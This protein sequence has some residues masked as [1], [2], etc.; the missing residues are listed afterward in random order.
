MVFVSRS[1]WFG[2]LPLA[3]LVAA[4]VL[5]PERAAY[6]QE[7]RSLKERFLTEAP[8]A[9]EEYRPFA[10]RLSGTITTQST[11]TELNTGKVVPNTRVKI[12]C[13]QKEGHRLFAIEPL[14]GPTLDPMVLAA[15]PRYAFRLKRPKDKTDWLLSHLDLK[16]LDGTT[17]DLEAMPLPERIHQSVAQHFEAYSIPLSTRI[18]EPSFKV[19]RATAVTQDGREFVRID[20]DNGDPMPQKNRAYDGLKSGSLLFDPD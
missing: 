10:A 1:R 11:L 15:N 16:V 20:F 18:R 12:E 19:L 4:L 6:G 7:S 14:E 13:K 5:V 2:W 8:K 9:W 3:A 17:V